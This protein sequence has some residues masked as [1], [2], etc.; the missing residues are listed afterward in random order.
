M[1]KVRPS[2]NVVDEQIFLV[3]VMSAVSIDASAFEKVVKQMK[4]GK[5]PLSL[6]N[7]KPRLNLPTAAHTFVSLNRAAKAAFSVDEADDPLLESWPF[8]LIV[9]TGHVVT[10]H[11]TDTLVSVCDTKAVAPDTRSSQHLA[12]CTHAIASVRGRPWLR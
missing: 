3:I 5:T 8:L 2:K 11:H 10:A 1:T 9:R 7:R 6:N 4:N 12:N